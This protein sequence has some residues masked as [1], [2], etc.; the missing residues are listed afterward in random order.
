M[1]YL[2]VS[3]ATKGSEYVGCLQRLK[4]STKKRVMTL[5]FRD[6]G[7]WAENT[8][9]K[10]DALRMALDVFPVVLWVDADCLLDFPEHLPP[11]DW[12]VC[13]AENCHPRHKVRISAAYLL[14]RNTLGG[15]RFLDA[16]EQANKRHKKDHPALRDVI[17]SASGF[18][19][20]DMTDWIRGRQPLFDSP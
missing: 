13:V 11:G 3:A 4:A 20:G 16:W 1:D 15:Q 2:I 10:V 17:E 5:Q 12:D 9:I 7:S 18:R 14:V 6:R 19:V 8:K